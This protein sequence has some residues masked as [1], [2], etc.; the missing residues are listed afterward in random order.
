MR[1]RMERAH[2]GN[3]IFPPIPLSGYHLWSQSILLRLTVGQHQTRILLL[4]MHLS[5]KRLSRWV[6]GESISPFGWFIRVRTGSLI[7]TKYIRLCWLRFSTI[8]SHLGS[9]VANHRIS[10]FLFRATFCGI[11][12][13]SP[14]GLILLHSSQR[15]SWLLGQ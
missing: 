12:A 10:L 11:L 15:A 9:C 3:L 14:I 6:Q 4:M 7:C 13:V 5:A 1:V 8:V 2:Q